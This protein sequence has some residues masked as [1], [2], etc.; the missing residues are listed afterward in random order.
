M[1]Q[2]L[3]AEPEDRFFEELKHRLSSEDFQLIRAKTLQEFLRLLRTKKFDLTIISSELQESE[4]LIKELSY[5]PKE[6]PLIIITPAGE[7]DSAKNW[8]K[9]NVCRVIERS[10]SQLSW[11]PGIVNRLIQEEKFKDQL[12]QSEQKYRQIFQKAPDGFILVDEKGKVEDINSSAMEILALPRQDFL[13]KSITELYPKESNLGSLFSSLVIKNQIIKNV[14]LELLS[15]DRKKLVLI[16]SLILHFP[17][18]QFYLIWLREISETEKTELTLKETE[19]RFQN[20][21]QNLGTMI[22][23]LDEQ[24]NIVDA[25]RPVEKWLGMS[26]TELRSLNIFKLIEE[27][28]VARWRDQFQDSVA[29]DGRYRGQLEISVWGKRRTVGM[30][31]TLLKKGEKTSGYL[32]G[33]QDISYRE[34]LKK[35]KRELQMELIEKNRLASLGNLVHGIAHNLNNPLA[36]IQATTQYLLEAEDKE[37]NLK[38]EL[39]TI[40]EQTQRIGQIIKDLMAKSREEAL[41][42]ITKLNLNQI[43]EEEIKFLQANSFF[44]YEVRLEK[45][46]S[47]L[48]A[49][50]GIY[51]DFSQAFAN[52]INNA[53]EAMQDSPV[54]ALKIKTYSSDSA[55]VIEIADTGR[56][57]GKE[58][59]SHLFEPF[60]TTKRQKQVKEGEPPISGGYGLGLYTTRFLLEPYGARFEVESEPNKG[61]LFRVIIPIQPLSQSRILI[62]SKDP[63][64]R[65]VSEKAQSPLAKELVVMEHF[66]EMV[67]LM[68]KKRF[69]YLVIDLES[70]EPDWKGQVNSLE[71]LAMEA[72]WIFLTAQSPE[73]IQLE[74]TPKVRHII[75]QKPVQPS[76]LSQALL[77]LESERY[78]ISGF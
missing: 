69:E 48:P 26:K 25:N 70:L 61:T 29:R 16:N 8:L 52:F 63:E 33:Y 68:E 59:I 15:G 2:V 13:S 49:I 31:A 67:A 4:S 28:E 40:K 10:E 44:K 53:L 65:L 30:T 12:F 24:G 23:M 47:P 45:E 78:H 58:L 37:V 43:L 17:A 5:E 62:F 41:R 14:K 19:E 21:F 71:K 34:Q 51:S 64:F 54:K 50:L 32:I 74:L 20:L 1:N 36:I 27:Q 22:I 38:E 56:G 42:V 11:L 72:R 46:L 73:L 60:F 3:V 76:E 39:T 66:E 7:I 75:L 9:L 57:M 77:L 6:T 18:R 35:A 55:I